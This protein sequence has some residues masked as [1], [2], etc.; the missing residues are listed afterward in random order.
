MTDAKNALQQ[1][2]NA[3]LSGHH[4][5][6]AT[7]IDFFWEDATSEECMA[8]IRIVSQ[9]AVLLQKSPHHTRQN[10][11]DATNDFLLYAR[12]SLISLVL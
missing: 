7:V 5:Q 10:P 4:E 11:H 9:D 3:P 8:L 2:R 1:L 6:W 12:R